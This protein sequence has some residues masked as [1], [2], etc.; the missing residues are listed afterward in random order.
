MA[1]KE[2]KVNSA[3]K[4]NTRKVGS[5]GNGTV[6]RSATTG[7]YVTRSAV[8]DPSVRAREI[9]E[10]PCGGPP[11]LGLLGARARRQGLLLPPQYH[12]RALMNLWIRPGR[13]RIT[14]V[15]TFGVAD[16]S[17]G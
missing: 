9:R 2:R 15:T 14:E 11:F 5:S 6:Y 12:V 16:R 10:A 13:G 17:G 4:A 3:V 1:D 8:R 7:R